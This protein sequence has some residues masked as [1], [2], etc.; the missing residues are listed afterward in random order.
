MGRTLRETLTG[1]TFKVTL[2]LAADVQAKY[3]ES[4][5]A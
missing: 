3:G 1:M 4:G 5:I 2:P